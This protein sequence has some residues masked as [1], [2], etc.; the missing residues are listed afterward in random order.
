LL[1]AMFL[2]LTL[3]SGAGS[4]LIIPRVDK[5]PTIGAFLEMKCPEEWLGKLAMVDDFTQREPQD[6]EP[7]TQRMI[8]YLGYDTKHLYVIFQAFDLEPSRVRASLTGRE[9]IDRDDTVNIQLDTFSDHRRGYTFIC[10]P[11]GIQADAIW[12][13]GEG[14][15]F[16]FNA[17]WYSEGKLTSK[18]FVVMMVIPFKSLRF[19]KQESQEWGILLNRDTPRLNEDVF[20]P[21]YSMKI[22]GRLNQAGT[23]SGIE[24]ISHGRNYQ[25]IPFGFARS[26]RSLEDGSSPGF[27]EDDMEHVL[28]LDAKVVLKDRFVVDMTFNPDFSQVESDQPQITTNQRFEVF[29]PERR[30]FFLENADMFTTPSQLVFTR[31]IQDP[32]WGL[33]LTGKA[34]AYGIGFMA[35][36]DAAPGKAETPDSPLTSEK[37][38]IGIL[39]VNRDIFN[40]S[41]IG[42]LM[43]NRDF[44][45]RSN[46]VFA[47]DTRMILTE[48]WVASAQAG[49][50]ETK[51]QNGQEMESSFTNLIFNRSGRSFNTHIHFLTTGEDFRADLGYLGSLHRTGTKNLH[52]SGSYTIWKNK[53]QWISW[54]PGFS[55]SYITGPDGRVVERA[56][57]PYAEFDFVGK[58]ELELKFNRTEE[59]LTQDEFSGMAQDEMF[60]SNLYLVSVANHMLDWLGLEAEFEWGDAVNYAPLE[61][62]SPFSADAE[63]GGIELIFKPLQNL[64]IGLNYLFS[65]LMQNQN[66]AII[67]SNQIYRN[68]VDWQLSRQ[69]SLRAIVELSRI[70]TDQE[71][72]FLKEREILNT[73]I[74]LTYKI[75]PWTAI[76]LGYNTNERNRQ[77]IGSEDN[78]FILDPS[79]N[80]HHDGSQIFVKCSYLVQ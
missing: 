39:R 30:P 36:N 16:S 74:L 49:I 23:L 76:Y 61:G 51:N 38:T 41:T 56:A 77:L 78:P 6:G 75:N 60:V 42:I 69:M 67:F 72:T 12:T 79:E 37:A 35:L 44:G 71:M 27:I 65:D 54:A 18:G 59:L 70:K 34:G 19:P 45:E 9:Q 52:G 62:T 24:D 20:W 68:R 43:T 73:D 7:A 26:Y 50:S 2:F 47:L 28:G 57:G 1:S 3:P 22:Q 48:H 46:R 4:K 63:K 21:H 14:Y 10:N 32:D 17:L 80:R 66:H 64:N 15:D 13:E 40:Q 33:R 58:S 55:A 25:L 5:P 53:P 8:T 11:Y 31:R 29:Y